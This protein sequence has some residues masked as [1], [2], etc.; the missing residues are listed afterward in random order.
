MGLAVDLTEF[1]WHRFSSRIRNCSITSPFDSEI[2]LAQSQAFGPRKEHVQTKLP[3]YLT[4]A[5]VTS[6]R[7][8]RQY[9]SGLPPLSV[10]ACRQGQQGT[11]PHST[12]RVSR[13]QQGIR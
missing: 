10:G 8:Q 11:R 12:A 9:T 4:S 5:N 2:R 1:N 7:P 6:G 13:Q 3:T